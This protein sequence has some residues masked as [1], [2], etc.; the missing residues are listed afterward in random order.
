MLQLCLSLKICEIVTLVPRFGVL[1]DHKGWYQNPWYRQDSARITNSYVERTFATARI[2]Y[3]QVLLN[4]AYHGSDLRI[5]RMWS[6]PTSLF[7][8][9]IIVPLLELD[10]IAVASSP[11]LVII[12]WISGPI[13]KYH[14]IDKHP[15]LHIL[16]GLSPS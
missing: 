3:G 1:T 15:S 12:R 5:Q 6:C 8:R 2:Y 7:N 11:C 9:V 10:P 16:D 14:P 4:V 13:P